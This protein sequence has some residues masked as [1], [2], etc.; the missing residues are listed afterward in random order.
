MQKILKV[1]RREFIETVKTKTFIFGVLMTPIII[2]GII[3]FTSRISRDKGGPRPPMKVA[4]TDLSK[5]LSAEIKTSFDKYNDSNTER[6]ILLQQLQPQE[7]SEA[8]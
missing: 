6:Q 4:V 8:V 2:G 5:E 3:F 7:N 1:A